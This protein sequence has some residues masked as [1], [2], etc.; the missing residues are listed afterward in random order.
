MS[1]DELL[2]NMSQVGMFVVCLS[3]SQ[4]VSQCHEELCKILEEFLSV[5]SLFDCH[6]ISVEL[7]PMYD[8]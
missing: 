4:S 2:V 7:V 6:N 5:S 1:Y 3:V 8:N